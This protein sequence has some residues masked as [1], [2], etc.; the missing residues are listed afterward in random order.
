[1]QFAIGLHKVGAQEA[2][3][4]IFEAHCLSD[5]HAFK[6][7]LDVVHRCQIIRIDHCNSDFIV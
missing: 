3:K 6:S 4:V 5:F 2:F 7:E 1:M